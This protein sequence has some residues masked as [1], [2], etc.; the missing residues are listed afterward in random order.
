MSIGPKV[1]QL[2]EMAE[3]GQFLE[4]LR[5]FYAVD[6]QVQ[7]NDASPRIGLQALLDNE[8]RV[9]SVFQNVSGKALRTFVDGNEAIIHWSFEF[10]T[11]DGVVIG[12]DEL[13]YQTWRDGQIVRE[14][15]Y[16]DP[17]QIQ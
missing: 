4:S 2:I 14:K 15:F 12:L 11:Q 9:L 3:R 16:Y 5:S 17:A 6:A 8:R 1:N 10:V 13:A 7:E